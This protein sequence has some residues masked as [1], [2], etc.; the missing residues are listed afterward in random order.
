[1]SAP[2]IVI[3]WRE[4]ST[5]LRVHARDRLRSHL[6]GIG[7][8]IALAEMDGDAWSPGGARNM[9]V[10]VA[11]FDPILFVDADTL[12]PHE[13]MHAALELAAAAPG[14]VYG[15]T[16]YVRMTAGGREGETI[17]NA[18]SMG[19]AAISR[20]CFDEVG[21]F[22][23]SFTGWGYED[24]E[25]ALRCNRLWRNRRVEG[26]CRHLW[27]GERNG[28]DSP[29]DSDPDEVKAN[30]DRWQTSLLSTA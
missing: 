28:D 6:K 29:A 8:G 22:D 1:M 4:P 24:L 13:Q 5:S 17:Y 25:F 12:T 14:L 3:P 15:Y 21:G 7:V 20:A 30:L 2:G 10:Q 9:G 23:E 26:V 19:C 18:P 27:H 11:D 16:L